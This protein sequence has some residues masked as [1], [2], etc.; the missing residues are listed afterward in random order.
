MCATLS[1]E[2]H[3]RQGTWPFI[4]NT[5]KLSPMLKANETLCNSAF[6]AN[7]SAGPDGWGQCVQDDSDSSFLFIFAFTFFVNNAKRSVKHSRAIMWTLSWPPR[8]NKAT[9]MSECQYSAVK[10]RDSSLALCSII[11]IPNPTYM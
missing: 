1:R 2:P 9:R 11:Y 5:C 8:D 7:G 6:Y 4:I 3:K 10:R